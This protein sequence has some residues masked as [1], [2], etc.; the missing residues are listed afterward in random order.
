M[1]RARRVVHGD[2]YATPES[3][4]RLDAPRY[5]FLQSLIRIVT[6]VQKKPGTGKCRGSKFSRMNLTNSSNGRRMLERSEAQEA[7]AI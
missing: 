1:L 2:G 7:K 6:H 3:L 5:V 4:E